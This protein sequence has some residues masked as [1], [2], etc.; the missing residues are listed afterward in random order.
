MEPKSEQICFE[1]FC[2]MEQICSYCKWF[3]RSR[4]YRNGFFLSS[5]KSY[6]KRS[7]SGTAGCQV[8]F[9]FF[10]LEF[11]IKSKA[12][13]FLSLFTLIGCQNPM[14]AF[15]QS[16]A[17]ILQ[18][19]FGIKLDC[20]GNFFFFFFLSHLTSIKRNCQCFESFPWI[21]SNTIKLVYIL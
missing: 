1:L 5:R 13:S 6:V 18:M 11:P 9:L 4:I 2:S 12:K 3:H 20:F 8:Y 15:H 7:A 16:L 10:F 21:I 14:S 19:C 17:T